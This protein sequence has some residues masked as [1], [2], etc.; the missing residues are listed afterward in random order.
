MNP[1]EPLEERVSDWL[2]G[3]LDPQEARA[4]EEELARQGRLQ[5]ARELARMVRL[6]GEAPREAPPEDLA[7][8]ILARIREGSP[9]EALSAGRRRSLPWILS[10][11]AAAAAALL[12]YLTLPGGASRPAQAP[13]V[14][15]ARRTPSG[16]A[17]RRSRGPAEAAPGGKKGLPGG[18]EEAEKEAPQAEVLEKRPFRLEAEEDGEARNKKKA[19]PS[20]SGKKK[21]GLARG[22][23]GKAWKKVGRKGGAPGGSPA[24]TAK[25]EQNPPAP[26]APSGSSRRAGK[27]RSGRNV[28]GAGPPAGR[29]GA[30]EGGR[31]GGG[32]PSRKKAARRD[33]QG[34]PPLPEGRE[35]ALPARRS[36]MVRLGE[37]DSLRK[38]KE[39]KKRKKE[40]FLLPRRVLA[41]S[42]PS[43]ESLGLEAFLS[44]GLRL[45]SRA[46]A[47]GALPAGFLSGENGG[48]PGKRKV[49]LLT[50]SGP[51]DLVGRAL[52]AAV[53][54]ARKAS[55][56]LLRLPPPP[57]A[58]KGGL[59]MEVLVVLEEG[60]R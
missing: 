2:E 55:S 42:A 5:E 6:L 41:L 44:R 57:A 38:G 11:S 47:A 36:G 29:P 8:K 7:G 32:L 31:I 18:G 43:L 39:E 49:L 34:A 1:R 30:P 24:E 37:E 9:G 35:E 13:G 4:L 15:V 50:L 19:A 28:L 22:P 25:K 48:A 46:L 40:A 21:G 27:A 52:R 54:K 33:R 60:R 17:G 58:G 3:R 45:R 59:S 20:P 14:E 10:L 51:K 23:G 16:E 53:G 56:V 26:A 12:V